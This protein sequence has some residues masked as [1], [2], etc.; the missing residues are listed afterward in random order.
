MEFRARNGETMF[1][2]NES[3]LMV[4]FK[5]GIA[6][7]SDKKVIEEMIKNGYKSIGSETIS[8]PKTSII[9]KTN[10]PQPKFKV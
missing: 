9:D 4:I 5:D 2:A 8:T 6:K 1:W 10:K 3:N 7:V